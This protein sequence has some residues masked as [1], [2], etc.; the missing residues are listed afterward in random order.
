[1][2]CINF[3]IQVNILA[4]PTLEIN[5]YKETGVLMF[6][7]LTN[8]EIIHSYKKKLRSPRYT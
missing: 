4:K 1:M 3:L 7:R 6:S 5:K 8:S 2:E